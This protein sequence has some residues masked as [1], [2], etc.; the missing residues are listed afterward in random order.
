MN[1]LASATAAWLLTYAVH[2]T[3]L[4]GLAWAF[5]YAGARSVL[6]SL[7]EVEDASTAELM[8]RFY[9][10]LRGEASKAD[11]ARHATRR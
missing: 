7:W 11:L 8:R 3:I 4:L 6:A 10:A 5:E 9:R 1:A 2:S